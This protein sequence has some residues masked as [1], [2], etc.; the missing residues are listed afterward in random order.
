MVYINDKNQSRVSCFRLALISLTKTR[1]KAYNLICFT[2]RTI[3]F[4][5]NY[6]LSTY[7]LN[8]Y[9]MSIYLL[10]LPLTMNCNNVIF[11]LLL[12]CFLLKVIL[13]S[14]RE[15]S[16]QTLMFWLM[17]VSFI[18]GRY[19]FYWFVGTPYT[20]IWARITS[21]T[22]YLVGTSLFVILTSSLYRQ[23]EF[24]QELKFLVWW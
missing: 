9:K 18:G 8:Y 16:L 21:S 14:C 7:I 15:H 17:I 12:L 1:R 20:Y 4:T 2:L 22:F 19:H 3:C 10:V 6:M 5:L 11:Y 24:I 23:E 13:L